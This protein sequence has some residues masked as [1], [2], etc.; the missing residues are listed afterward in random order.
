MREKEKFAWLNGCFDI[1]HCGHLEL[2][3]AAEDFADKVIVGI[4]SDERIRQRKGRQ[5]IFN[6]YERAEMLSAIWNVHT[7]VIFDSDE[8]LRFEIQNSGAKTIIVGQEYEGKV[9]GA[10]FADR[11][12]Y[13]PRIKPLSTT[14]IIEKIKNLTNA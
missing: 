10:E 6:Q 14:T 4:D 9:I 7:V 1:L 12:V 13:V 8:R 11:I 5:P 2:F 3:R